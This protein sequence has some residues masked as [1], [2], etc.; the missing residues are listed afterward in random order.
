MQIS[1]IYRNQKLKTCLSLTESRKLVP[2][3]TIL[4]IIVRP[5]ASYHFPVLEPR[6]L[7]FGGSSGAAAC[8]VAV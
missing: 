7:F 1:C 4:H 2:G 8:V 6:A 5:A 3:P